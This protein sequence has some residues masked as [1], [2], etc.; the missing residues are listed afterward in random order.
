MALQDAEQGTGFCLID[1]HGDLA[2]ELADRV[3][4]GALV[5]RPYDRDC[6]LGYNPLTRTSPALRPLVTSG[7]I[8]TLRHQWADA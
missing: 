3:G 1:P 4:D 8:A 7:L 2:E 6:P 5:W